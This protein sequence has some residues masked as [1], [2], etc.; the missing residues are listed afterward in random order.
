[1]TMDGD[2]TTTVDAID[3]RLL[4][5]A[6]AE[7]ELRTL[8]V[9][10]TPAEVDE[11]RVEVVRLTG[12]AAE[13]A[14]K[15]ESEKEAAKQRVKAVEG[16]LASARAQATTLARYASTGEEPRQVEVAVVVDRAARK[17]LVVRRDTG[18]VVESRSA[19]PDEVEAGCDWVQDLEK[20]VARL[21]HAPTGVVVRTR[22]LTAEE[23]QLTIDATA[24]RELVWIG[25]GV[26]AQLTADEVEAL[27]CPVPKGTRVKWIA[28]GDAWMHVSAPKGP[29]LDGLMHQLARLDIAFKVGND[30][31]KTIGDLARRRDADR[32]KVASVKGGRRA[33]KGEQ[34]DGG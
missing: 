28:A 16:E 23:R 25:A 6:D 20:G 15:V 26:W 14:V 18:A 27:E 32:G 21:T 13:L 7:A 3:A 5:D 30:A 4:A 17:R 31:P 2:K 8:P 34:G 19:A 10:L 9:K 11:R 22:I 24:P 29:T 1:M 12:V 33:S